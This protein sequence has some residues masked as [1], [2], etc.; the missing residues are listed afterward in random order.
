ME[1]III[2]DEQIASDSLEQ[3]IRST[4]S[5]IRVLAKIES[6]RN[7]VNWLINNTCDLIFLDIQLSDGISFTIFE[8]VEVKIPIIFTTAYDQYAI[9]AF[10]LNSIDYLL[11]PIDIHE[12]KQSLFKYKDLHT[13]KSYESKVIDFKE[14]IESI[15]NPVQYQSRF[16]VYA[17][18]KIRSVKVSTIAYFYTR[19]GSVFF[20]T[21]E[22]KQ[23][24]IDHTLDKL[25]QILDPTFF[26]RIN[27]Q[28]IVNIEAIDQ[29]HPMSK[30]R[31]KLDLK[32]A[33]D[34]EAVVSF[35]HVQDFK[36]WLNR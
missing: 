10:K 35:N 13:S 26:F 19:E 27:R 5:S 2:E 6:V 4:D 24:D 9:K 11:K 33:S 18:Q 1:V 29:M 25:E 14:L 22:G 23:Y 3:I 7:A 28:F 32:P 15:R 17:G 8:Q 36:S 34:L 31:L 21:N 12:L 20:C 16:M 30:S